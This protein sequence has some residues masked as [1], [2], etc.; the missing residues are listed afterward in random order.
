MNVVFNEDNFNRPIQGAEGNAVV[1]L[2]KLRNDGIPLLPSQVEGNVKD[3]M[4]SGTMVRTADVS[5]LE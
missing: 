4:S 2:T 5:H 1:L 3:D